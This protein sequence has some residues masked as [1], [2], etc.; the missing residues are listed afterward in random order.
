MPRKVEISHKTIIFTLILL[1]GLWVVFLIR[2]IILQFF[3]ALLL[4]TILE[5]LVN[6]L[7]KFRV[8]RALSVLISYLLV[9]G[10]V[11]GMIALIAPVLVTQS[12]SFV[13]S[14]PTYLGKI[15]ITSRISTQVSGNLL[16]AFGNLPGQFLTL[17]LS[18]FSNI[19]SVLTVLVFAFYLLLSRDR[20]D[21]QLGIFFGEERQK[22]FGNLIDKLEDKLGGW[23]RAELTLMLI[24]GVTTY[25]GL[26]ILGIPFAL[27]LAVLAGIFEIIPYLGPVVSA[28]PAVIIGFGISPLTGIGAIAMSFLVH[29]LEGY[30]FFP[31]IMEKRVG[32]S[33]I[34]TLIALAIGSRLAGI[35]GVI[36]SV[37]VLITLQVLAKE[38][39]VKE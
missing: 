34:I 26:I 2:D 12:A 13:E 27:P 16:T 15:G 28:V 36:I 24:V 19:F 10:F 11:G 4:M 25:L 8:P 23:A 14:L 31:K 7:S 17:T 18:I 38:Y 22:Q 5:P 6:K 32:V 29:Q 3:I 1:L 9:I 33:P 30:V 20:L 37:P 35:V 21:D 39:L